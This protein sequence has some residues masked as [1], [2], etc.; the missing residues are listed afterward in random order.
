ME[1][2]NLF[3]RDFY[4]LPCS[5]FN[6]SLSSFSYVRE[7]FLWDGVTVFTNEM[8]F[9]PLVDAVRSRVKVGWL[10]EP[11][12]IKGHLY[13][14]L[15]R[16]EHRFDFIMT[17]DELLLKD[18]EKYKFAPAGGC[19]IDKENYFIHDKTKLVN[20]IASGKNFAPGHRM[21]H[22]VIDAH[23]DRMEVLGRG[24]NPVEK[25]ETALKDYMFSIA[26]ENSS[27]KNYFTEKLLDCFAMGTIPIYWGCTNIGDFFD[28]RG[29]LFLNS[30]EE[31]GKLLESL[32]YSLYE[33]M[34]PYVENNFKLFRKYEITEEWIYH[35]YFKEALHK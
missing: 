6:K 30:S 33:K 10:V 20:I 14:A 12:S 11:R 22:E 7:H 19:W 15:P 26:I 35:N 16:I 18:E 21:R 9:E 27:V 5:I 24:Y 8:M 17:H 4:G 29:I 1:K 31:C 23:G 34:L 2:I 3:D 13:E 32:D 25:K 28:E